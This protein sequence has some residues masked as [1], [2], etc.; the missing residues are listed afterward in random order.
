MDDHTL[1]ERLSAFVTPARRSLFDRIA[2]ERTAHITVVLEDVF[3]SHNA[4]AVLRTCDLLGV[5][6]VHAIST[7]NRFATNPEIALGSE[8]WITVHHHAGPDAVPSAVEALRAKGYRLIATLPRADAH[9]PEDVPIDA[10]LA[11]CFGTEL[12]GLSDDL[13]SRCDGAL[14]IP[15]FGFT[16][17]YNISVAA[18]ITLY[19]VMRK[20]RTSSIAHR[21]NED[22]LLALKLR[23]L[24]AS[25]HDSASIEQRIIEDD[26]R[27]RFDR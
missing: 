6:H 2:P 5:Q 22:D 13:A 9:T 21:M 16:E 25:V 14:R 7:R 12:E 24:R 8:K 19:T 4:S 11:F 26:A 10:P 27:T 20:L 18:A 23:W 15:M 3:Q 17:S 1:Y